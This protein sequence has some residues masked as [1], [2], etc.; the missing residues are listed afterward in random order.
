MPSCPFF[1]IDAFADAPLQGNPAAVCLLSEPADPAWMQRVAAEMNLSETAFVV[2]EGDGY[3]LRWFTPEVEVP[4]CGHGTLAAA[5][6]LF[7]E[8][9]EG[10]ESTGG[11]AASS[12]AFSTKSG[13][14]DAVRDGDRIRLDF[15]ARTLTP[16][17][18]P[19][20]V[21]AAVRVAPVSCHRVEVGE[22]VP[23]F[24]LELPD[25]RRVREL[26]ARLVGL[27]RPTAPSFC[28]T[29]RSD[30]PAYDFVSRFFAP[31]HGIDEDPVTGSA[32]CALAPFWRE[33][34]GKDEMVGHQV[35]ARGGVVGV[36]VAGDRVH[37][38][39]RAV[40]IVR[41]ELQA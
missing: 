8:C 13:R 25:A 38:L 7:S 9:T 19:G 2:R 14:L 18:A 24:L 27:R 37:L 41:G 17:D 36:R 26:E 11:N 32:H 20:E 33:R 34:L 3:G 30:D 28:V 39:G 22:D 5:H 15:P 29:A 6:A 10:T 35:S 21:L 12:L 1:I 23:M 40:T 4:L 16:V 31:G